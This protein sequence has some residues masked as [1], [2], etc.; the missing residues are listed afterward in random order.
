MVAILD[1]PVMDLVMAATVVIVVDGDLGVGTLVVGQVLEQL[2]EALQALA[3]QE[4]DSV[5]CK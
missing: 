1:T 2:Q 4:E 5:R 3:Q